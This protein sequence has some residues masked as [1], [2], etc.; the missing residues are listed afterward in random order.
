MTD[1]LIDYDGLGLAELIRTGQISAAEL[2]ETVIERIERLNPTLNFMT[3][4][5]YDLARALAAAPPTEGAFAGVPWLLKDLILSHAGVPQTSGSR[6]F[7]D[8]VPA[9]DSLM[10]TRLKTLGLIYMGSTNVPEF[11]V[12]L[13]TSNAL[14]GATRNPWDVTRTPGGSSG[15]AAAAVAARVLP[16]GYCGLVGLKPSRGRNSYF[17]DYADV[18]YGCGTDACVSISVRDTAAYSD[19]MWGSTPGDPYEIPGLS[20]PLIEEVGA[21]PG[22]LRIGLVT[23]SPGNLA[24]EPDASRAAENAAR[25]CESLG[26]SVEVTELPINYAEF[27]ETFVRTVGVLTAMGLK[28]AEQL[29]GRAAGPDDVQPIVAAMRAMAADVSGIDHAEDVETLRRIGR[30]IAMQVAR[31]DVV[32]TPTT[33][34]SAPAVGDPSQAWTDL[35][36]YNE[37]LFDYM[38]F[39]GPISVSGL[40]AMSLPLHWGATGMPFGV[41]FIASRGREDLLIRL[42]AQLEVAQPWKM[43]KPPILA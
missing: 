15:G 3:H 28:G 18:W 5:G 2:A 6:F 31:F 12:N 10:I 39:V 11:G 9:Q 37:K 13:E 21:D 25:L 24:P 38:A 23:R 16:A 17:P 30:D 19:A 43:R 27:S 40:P 8:Y 4:K 14:F 34:L 41:Q 33:P 36:A 35:A 32:I 26:H 22:R 20:R 29:M 42:A 7:K 1:Q